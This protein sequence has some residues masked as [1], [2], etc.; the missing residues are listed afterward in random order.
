MLKKLASFFFVLVFICES[1][2][3]L[4]YKAKEEEMFERS[5]SLDSIP[6]RRGWWHNITVVISAF[7]SGLFP[8]QKDITEANQS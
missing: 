4:F 8:S 6:V 5:N 7:F 3:L 1:I 2:Y